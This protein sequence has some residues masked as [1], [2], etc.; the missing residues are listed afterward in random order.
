[1]TL[2]I[3]FPLLVANDQTSVNKWQSVSEF[4]KQS[5][6][7]NV[8]AFTDVFIDTFSFQEMSFV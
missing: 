7:R 3:F 2:S 5:K 1:M 6:T 8:T 4:T